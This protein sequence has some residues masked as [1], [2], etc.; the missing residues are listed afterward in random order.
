[1]AAPETIEEFNQRLRSVSGGLPKRL[2]QCAEY[3]GAHTDQIALSTVADLSGRAGVQPSAM[4]RFC[5]VMG[6]DGFSDMQTLFRKSVSGAVPNYSKRLDDLRQGGSDSPTALLAEFAD[7]GRRSLEKLATTISDGELEGAVTT[8]LAAKTIHIMGLRRAFPVAAYLSYAFE[9]MN[10]QSVLH[11]GV[12]GLMQYHA[13]T[14]SDALI[15]I[16]FAPYS[17]ETVSFASS[18]ARQGVPVVA[19]SDSSISPVQLEGVQTLLVP[20]IDFGN[21]RSLSASLCL[22][23][24]MAIA[25][26]TERNTST[27]EN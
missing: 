21:F 11:D 18:C 1:M 26:G 13:V 5:Q 19:L 4:M 24:T 6:F 3:L 8:L 23:I 25:V 9:K 15:A 22:A 2:R 10:I 27:V 7:A 12:G 17:A 14:E 16:T 20:E